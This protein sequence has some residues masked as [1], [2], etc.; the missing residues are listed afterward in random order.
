MWIVLDEIFHLLGP[1]Q[2][3]CT[4]GAS[5]YLHK[6]MERIGTAESGNV[7]LVCGSKQ[8]IHNG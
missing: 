1:R 4:S 7:G 6:L 2:I 8:V 5:K 3:G